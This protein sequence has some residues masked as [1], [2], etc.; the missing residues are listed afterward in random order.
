MQE[1]FQPSGEKD[2]L[3]SLRRF[4][5]EMAKREPVDEDALEKLMSFYAN[6]NYKEDPLGNLPPSAAKFVLRVQ[7]KAA[8]E[9]DYHPFF[10]RVKEVAL[11][12][13]SKET[14]QL[15][16]A[17]NYLVQKDLGILPELIPPLEVIE[18]VLRA[19]KDAPFYAGRAEMVGRMGV[20]PVLAH[21]VNQ[22]ES[23]SFAKVLKDFVRENW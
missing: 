6:P 7:Q 9:L 17:G 22:G 21:K 15:I 10:K 19:K 11:Q 2:F 12:R 14:Q 13:W 3:E 4:S 1:P 18:I 16:D 5:A 8:P 23:S 20:A